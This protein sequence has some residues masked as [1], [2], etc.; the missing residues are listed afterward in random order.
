MARKPMTPFWILMK[1]AYLLKCFIDLGHS[2]YKPHVLLFINNLMCLKYFLRACHNVLHCIS[3]W[4]AQAP[5]QAQVHHNSRVCSISC[6]VYIKNSLNTWTNI[7]DSLN[8][9]S[10]MN[11]F[12]SWPN[13]CVFS[14]KEHTNQ[15]Q[16]LVHKWVGCMFRFGEINQRFTFHFHASNSTRIS[17][18]CIWWFKSVYVSFVYLRSLWKKIVI[19]TCIEEY[20]KHT[21]WLYPPK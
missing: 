20:S 7:C 6:C 4:K 10:T 14:S 3:C 13:W 11:W 9:S 17:T 12:S 16:V 19:Q 15:F 1:C 5:V 2:T 18:L 8:I 21:W